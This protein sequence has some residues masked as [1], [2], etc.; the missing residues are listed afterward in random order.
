MRSIRTWV[1]RS[2]VVLSLLG[3]PTDGHALEI[4]GLVS[5]PSAG[6]FTIPQLQ[7]LGA[8]AE[9]VG[10]DAFVGV[11][12]WSLLGGN[13]S[14]AS[15]ITT[16][17]GGN[18]PILRNFILA[19]GG[20]GQSLISAGEVDP[21]FGGTGPSYLVAYQK[22]GVTLGAPTLVVPQDMSRA[23]FVTELSEL[24]V[25]AVPRPPAGVRAPTTQLS[26]TG[27]DHP[28]TYDLAGLQALPPTT[29]T[30]VTFLA[31]GTVNGPHDYTGVEVWDFLVAAGISG[32]V[33]NSYVLATGSDGY[34]VLYSLAELNPA[35][36]ASP[37]LVAY[38]VDGGLL[39]D[40]DGFARMVIPGDLR[41][42]RYVSNIASLELAATPEPGTLAL[43]G[44]GLA[45]IAL[46]KWRARTRRKA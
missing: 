31:G 12:L 40:G 24:S 39:S 37:R 36:G 10:G 2:L 41:G 26:L 38:A 32:N 34:Q 42:G 16:V 9:V 7:A 6:S 1:A 44:T 4:T 30:G 28:A 3:W 14:G 27:V 8:T 15:N 45:G 13:A 25:G 19:T 46:G 20:S 17:G 11:S 29:L 43:L 33:L 18:N 22:N 21:V 23:R 35:F 5:G